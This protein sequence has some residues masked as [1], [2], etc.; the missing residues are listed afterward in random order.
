MKPDFDVVAGEYAAFRPQYPQSLSVR[1][2]SMGFIAQQH[3]VLDLGTGAANLGASLDPAPRF[4]TLLD[5]SPRMAGFAARKTHGRSAVAVVVGS[6]ESLPFADS[7]FDWVFAAQSWHLYDRTAAMPEVI[8]I[9]RPGGALGVL[10]LTRLEL[11]GDLVEL[12]NS[13]IRTYNPQ[14]AHDGAHGLYPEFLPELQRQGF[15]KIET[16]SYD[17]TLK[18]SLDDWVGRI[19]ASKGVGASLSAT[20]LRT[21]ATDLKQRVATAF[22]F[23]LDVPHRM[24]AIVARTA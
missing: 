11:G 22:S 13:L 1:L 19:V 24:F 21:F 3:T 18:Y 12:S 20:V 10:Y 5:K 15:L 6:A 8:R 16:F 14:W 9:L 7:S 17:I 2:Q 4:L 23:P